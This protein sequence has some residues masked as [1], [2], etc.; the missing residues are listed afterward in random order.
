MS[1]N[2]L[3]LLK[4][5]ASEASLLGKLGR[6]RQSVS[7]VLDALLNNGENYLTQSTWY[8]DPTNGNDNNDGATAATALRTPAELARR[9]A[10]RVYS[11]SVMDIT[12]NYLAGT[13][14]EPLVLSA[15]A[16]ISPT[17]VTIQ[18]QMQTLLSSTLTGVTN[19]NA[20]A[21]TRGAIAD[22][23]IADFTPYK[24]KRLRL[25]SGAANE[26]CTFVC[27]TIPGANA[28]NVG[29]WTSS[30]VSGQTNPSAND[31]YDIEDFLTKLPGLYVNL[32]GVPNVVVRDIEFTNQ[33]GNSTTSRMQQARGTFGGRATYFGCKWSSEAANHTHVIE[34]LFNRAACCLSSSVT[35]W[36]YNQVLCSAFGDCIFAG[37]TVSNAS[38]HTGNHTV[39]DGAGTKSVLVQLTNDS[40]IEDTNER[41]FFGNTGVHVFIQDDA[42]YICSNANARFW[43]AAG[44][45]GTNALTVFNGCQMS[46]V[47]LPTATANTPGSDVILAGAAAAAWAAMPAIAVAPDNA[48]VNVR[49]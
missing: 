32:A 2:L 20:G 15:C 9:W 12:V 19:V 31:T 26:E 16:F 3:G 18:G 45:T 43:G 1:A 7:K 46:Y 10:G 33:S 47:T 22:T 39:H 11:P 8:V 24:E 25:T 40:Y 6:W 48:T 21:G 23:N 38:A 30:T 49:H 36:F 4:S 29:Q 13:Y 27:P 28:A 44:N 42:Q 14:D 5:S 17:T 34:G 35:S 41:G 37:L